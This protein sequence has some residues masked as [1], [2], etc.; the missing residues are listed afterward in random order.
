M[1]DDEQ[2]P[3]TSPPERWHALKPL[4]RQMRHKATPA[5]NALWQRLR[6]G[7]LNGVRFR[8]QHAIGPWIVDFYCPAARLIVEVDGPIHASQQESDAER[9]AALE[10]YGLRVLRFS[11]DAVLGDIEAVVRDIA[12]VIGRSPTSPQPLSIGWRGAF[13]WPLD[14]LSRYLGYRAISAPPTGGGFPLSSL[15]RGG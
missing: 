13:R 1:S 3:A 2:S 6:G 14:C 9:Q 4:A 10:G 5:E 12:R 7:C 15:W 11:N 8:R